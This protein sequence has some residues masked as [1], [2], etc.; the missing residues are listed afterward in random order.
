M[1]QASFLPAAQPDLIR[2]SQKDDYYVQV[3]RDSLLAL[4]QRVLG[5]RR[6][7]VLDEEARNCGLR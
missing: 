6:A 1:A 2:A 5:P 3:L 7:L 4:A